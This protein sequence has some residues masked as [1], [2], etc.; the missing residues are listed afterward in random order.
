MPSALATSWLSTSFFTATFSNG[1]LRGASPRR[2]RA[3]A[4]DAAFPVSYHPMPTAI[5]APCCHELR[6]V[7][8]TY[9]GLGG[10]GFGGVQN[11]SALASSLYRGVS[12]NGGFANA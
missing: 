3:R 6:I 5:S 1:M 11:D 4:F 10:V 12:I 9:A 2:T 7:G 8:V